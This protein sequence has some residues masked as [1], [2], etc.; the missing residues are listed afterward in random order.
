MK[1][2]TIGE[3]PQASPD[4]AGAWAYSLPRAKFKG[5]TPAELL[6]YLKV[7]TAPRYMKRGI[8]T[9]CNIFAHDYCHLMGVY[10][11]RVWWSSEAVTRIARGED[12]PM[13][14]GRTV[15]EMNA[16]ALYTWL[17]TFGKAFGWVYINPED[18]EEGQGRVNL[19]AV[20]VICAQRKELQKPGHISVIVPEVKEPRPQTAYRRAGKILAPL[21]AQAGAVNFSY[22]HGLMSGLTPWQMSPVFHAW[23]VWTNNSNKKGNA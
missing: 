7:E 17:V 9:Y 5:R 6:A 18:T 12:V 23:G 2:V 4:V 13:E 16:N 20:G 3:H 10:L 14:Y 8:S 21:Q 22:G 19:G 11:P 15:F 1:E